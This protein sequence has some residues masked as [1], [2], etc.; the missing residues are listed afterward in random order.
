HQ[1]GLLVLADDAARFLAL[2][3][4]PDDSRLALRLGHLVFVVAETRFLVRL[5][6]DRLGVVVHVLAELAHDGIDLLLRKRLERSLGDP[7][8]GDELLHLAGRGRAGFPE[9]SA[10]SVLGSR[11]D[12]KCIPPRWSGRNQS[13]KPFPPPS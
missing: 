13:L 2:E 6:G 8:I 3:A 12:H 7:R 11:A 4:V 1:I 5:P 10:D 9:T